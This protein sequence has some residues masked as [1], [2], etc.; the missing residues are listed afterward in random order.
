[1]ILNILHIG[2]LHSIKRNSVQK[3]LPDT[4]NSKT[5]IADFHSDFFD[6]SFKLNE[7]FQESN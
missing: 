5:L 3:G 1:M 7:I 6:N 2:N 4:P